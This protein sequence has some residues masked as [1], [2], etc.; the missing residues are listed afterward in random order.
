MKQPHVTVK[1]IKLNVIEQ[2]RLQNFL[3]KQD[4]F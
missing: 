1:A 2:V 3:M 4:H